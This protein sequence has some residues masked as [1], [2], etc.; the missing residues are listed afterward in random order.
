M[1]NEIRNKIIEFCNPFYDSKDV[2]HNMSHVYRVIDKA[3]ELSKK[4]EVDFEEIEIGLYFHG[5]IKQKKKEIWLQLENF[6][7]SN[8]K[9]DRIIRIS[10]A[11]HKEDE[12]KSLEEKIVHDSH[13]LEGE[14]YFQIIKS[15]VTGTAR[16]Q[17]LEKTIEYFKNNIMGRF[18]CYL[19]E[20]KAILEEKE[21]KS[22]E[23]I[24]DIEKSLKISK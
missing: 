11:S 21:K 22:K 17:T 10:E 15:I 19:P 20:S 8:E 23:V 24:E 18:N 14:K 3:G 12:P 5:V 16:N 1:K 13:I 2:M 4:Y 7:F 6:G 9:I